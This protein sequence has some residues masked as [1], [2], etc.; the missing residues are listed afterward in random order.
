MTETYY[1][2][3]GDVLIRAAAIPEDAKHI[4]SMTLAEGETTGHAHRVEG[5]AHLL[6]LGER[7]FLRVLGGDCRVVHEEHKEQRIP[8]GDYEIARV[9]EYDHFA[10]EARNV[11]D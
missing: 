11:R 8:P 3:H 4:K 10:E 1:Q 2:Q 7:I 5:D 6:Q 9:Q